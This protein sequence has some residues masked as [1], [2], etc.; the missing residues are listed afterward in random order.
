MAMGF[1]T[2]GS[3]ARIEMLKPGSALILARASAGGVRIWLGSSVLNGVG[4]GELLVAPHAIPHG[5]SAASANARRR[6]SAFAE[7][8]QRATAIPVREPKG[9]GEK[10]S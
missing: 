4:N 7:R 2:S 8:S 3:E 6:K 9:R 10:F 5:D 1:W